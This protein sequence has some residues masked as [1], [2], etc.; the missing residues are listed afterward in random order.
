MT[1]PLWPSSVWFMLRL[2]GAAMPLLLSVVRPESSL[3]TFSS[4]FSPPHTIQPLTVFQFKLFSFTP[5]G[6]AIFLLR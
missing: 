3:S 5:F 4:P 1:E 6:I 2:E